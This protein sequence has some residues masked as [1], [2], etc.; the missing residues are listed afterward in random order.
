MYEAGKWSRWTIAAVILVF[1][2]LAKA[3]T[4][5]STNEATRALES[6][7]RASASSSGEGRASRPEGENTARTSLIP[8]KNFFG[9]F[10]LRPTYTGLSGEFH[11]ENTAQLGYKFSPDTTVSYIQYFNTR[12]YDPASSVS[13]GAVYLSDGWLYGQVNNILADQDKVN[14][15]GMR[16]LYIPPTDSAKRDLGF[17]GTFRTYFKYNHKF[18]NLYNL[19]VWNV[20]MAHIY[21]RA[22]T[23]VPGTNQ[24][25]PVFENEVILQHNF[26]ITEKLQFVFPIIWEYARYASYRADA[27]NSGRW[28]S[29]FWI[30]PEITYNVTPDTQVGL[31]YETDNLLQDDLSG[32]S[33]DNGFKKGLFQV[34]MNVNL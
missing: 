7:G 27:Q 29:T 6:E 34:L 10:E 8:T 12:L 19:D 25:N 21:S 28:V 4:T 24:A 11:T 14:T 16:E 22:G 5:V 15:F 23:T 18:S 31:A 30:W 9:F 1:A 13:R 17:I 20:P 3:E 33:W 26:N 2:P 32:A